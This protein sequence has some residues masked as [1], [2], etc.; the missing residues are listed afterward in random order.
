MIDRPVD[1]NQT[2]IG[3]AVAP[4]RAGGGVDPA[5]D[6]FGRAAG[7]IRRAIGLDQDD[8]FGPAVVEGGDEAFIAVP[9]ERLDRA[10]ELR[11]EVGRLVGLEV[12]CPED[13]LVGFEPGAGSG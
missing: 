13:P 7:L 3:L 10:V 4:K 12:D 5:G 9:A 8:W 11:A 2:R 6:K 1:V